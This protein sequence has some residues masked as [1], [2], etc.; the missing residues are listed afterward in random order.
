MIT[1]AGDSLINEIPDLGMEREELCAAVAEQNTVDLVTN[2]IYLQ[3]QALTICGIRLYG[4]P[5]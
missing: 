1:F 4:T 3:D 5:W 2:A